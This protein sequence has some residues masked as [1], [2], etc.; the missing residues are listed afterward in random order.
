[1]GAR[2][3]QGELS[4]LGHRLGAGTIPRILGNARPGPAP[5]R[6]DTPWRT[7]L[8]KQIQGPLAMDCFYINTIGLRRLYVLFVMEVRA[9]RVRV[10]GVAAHP[11]A[12]WTVQQARV[13]D[14]PRA[15]PDDARDADR[16]AGHGFPRLTRGGGAPARRRRPTVY[17]GLISCSPSR[18]L[19]PGCARCRG[20]A[21]T[22]CSCR[23]AA[24]TG[25]GSSPTLRSR[26][27]TAAVGW[28]RS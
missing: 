13:R 8:R 22:R 5:H 9:R 10:L 11:T 23:C 3:I 17:L 6:V 7:F 21:R 18:G 4:R 12:A 28:R 24:S 14:L 2:R 27:P 15:R 26:R 16:G 19:G 20:P 1:M 25:V